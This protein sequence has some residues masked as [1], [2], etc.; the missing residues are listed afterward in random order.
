[1]AQIQPKIPNNFV[2]S[3]NQST[4]KQ[5]HAFMQNLMHV[6]LINLN[7]SIKSQAIFYLFNFYLIKAKIVANTFILTVLAILNI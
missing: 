3:W 1:M 5:V 2:Y 6:K 7:G 4:R